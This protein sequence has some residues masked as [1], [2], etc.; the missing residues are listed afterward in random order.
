M[1][2]IATHGL[3]YTS[4]TNKLYVPDQHRDKVLLECHCTPFSG[5]LRYKKT[6]EQV[7][8]NFWWDSL[9]TSVRAF[10]RSCIVCQRT[11][12]NSALP[13]G[14][15]KPLPVPDSPWESVSMDLVTDLPVCCGYDS[16][17]VVVDR[18]TK[19][20]ILSPCK[21]TVTA[22]QL[23][24]LFI[25]NVFRRFGMPVNIV[26]DRDPRFTSHFWKSFTSLLGTELAM[27]TAYHPQ[28]D[29]QTERANRTFEDMLRGFVCPR[30][31]D[32]CRFLSLVEFAY[33][34]STLHSPFFLDHGRHPL[35]PISAAVPS[36]SEVPAVTEYV[37]S[38]QEALRSAKSNIVS[39]QQRMKAYADKK[40]RDHP[41][42]VGD[43]VFLMIRQNQLPPGMS[44]KL[45]AKFSGPWPIVAAVGSHA[46]KLDL[47]ATVNIHPV[48]HVSQLKPY[49]ASNTP[50]TPTQPPPLYADRRGGTYNVEAILGKRKH[51]SSWQYLV[52][53][54]G[55]DSTENTW[56]PLANVRHLVDMVAS[57]PLIS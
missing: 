46:F 16:V 52:K 10:C 39:A 25:D 34:N 26:S 5:H 55:Y 38:M 18:L 7:C 8:R 29:G 27:S 30:Q 41:F 53:W 36:R 50:D 12:G 20:V 32:W 33:N 31:N 37:S 24:Q 51:R 6:Y 42:R 48:F 1:A 56:E 3:L 13:Y 45:S 54:E 35:T 22:P 11:K 9:G 40:R 49:I 47:P 57:A 17:F 4:D 19:C 43:S 2:C 21:K 14:L 44:S 28:T 15:S 23:A